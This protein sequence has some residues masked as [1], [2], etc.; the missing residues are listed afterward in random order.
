MRKAAFYRMEARGRL[1]VGLDG[2]QPIPGAYFVTT[3][4]PMRAPALPAGSLA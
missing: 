1:K 4:Q 2:C 3:P